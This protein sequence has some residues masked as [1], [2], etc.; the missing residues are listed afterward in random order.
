M[1]QEYAACLAKRQ[2]TQLIQNHQVP[3][4]SFKAICPA[5]PHAFSTSKALTNS[6]V[7]KKRT[8]MPCFWI[9]ST[10][11]AVAKCVLP[12]LGPPMKTTL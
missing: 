5:L 12:V 6:T 4:T 3:Y 8:R 10:P 2:V 11:M 7:D 9:A 1:K